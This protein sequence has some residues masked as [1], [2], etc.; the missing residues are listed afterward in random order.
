MATRPSWSH[1][2]GQ[3]GEEHKKYK[4]QKFCLDCGAE[5]PQTPTQSIPVRPYFNRGHTPI[6]PIEIA[7]DDPPRRQLV[8]SENSVF[9]PGPVTTQ[10]RSLGEVGHHRARFGT[11]DKF[12]PTSL[13]VPD[14]QARTKSSNIKRSQRPSVTPQL[15]R[16][17]TYS[18][19]Q[20]FKIDLSVWLIFFVQSGEF[21]EFKKSY[22]TE[23]KNER[24]SKSCQ[25]LNI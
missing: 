1:V 14:A 13:R 22:D 17:G 9:V 20:G 8:G 18:H 5:N 11:Y 7:D 19:D 25:I 16:P 21:P 23:A 3:S 4:D 2:C 6:A 10:P 12:D 15:G 24:L